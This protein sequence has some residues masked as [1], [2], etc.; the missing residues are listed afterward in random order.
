M[1]IITIT[2]YPLVRAAISITLTA[3]ALPDAVIGLSTFQGQAE[4]EVISRDPLAMNY[5]PAGSDPDPVKWAHIITATIY[6]TAAYLIPSMPPPVTRER[7]GD[8]YEFQRPVWDS[9]ARAADLRALAGSE[10]GA[11]LTP[12]YIP[13]PTVFKAVHG[14]RGR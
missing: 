8:K 2:D 11:Y 5:A 1:P 4:A 3:E 14:Y 7:I 12:D 13:I 6:L 10:L 9:L